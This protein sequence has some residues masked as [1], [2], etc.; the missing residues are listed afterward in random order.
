MLG[1]FRP[2]GLYL[3]AGGLAWS[4]FFLGWCMSVASYPRVIVA[5]VAADIGPDRR[6]RLHGLPV[7]TGLNQ[8]PPNR[9]A[10]CWLSHL[11]ISPWDGGPRSGE[12][13]SYRTVGLQKFGLT[14]DCPV[15]SIVDTEPR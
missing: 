3:A 1:V 8:H 5:E 14:Y 11:L 10:V 12:L 9:L 4:S 2:I 7:D 15:R 6:K 13:R